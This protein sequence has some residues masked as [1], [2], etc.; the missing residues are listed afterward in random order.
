M[1][2]KYIKM[3]Y[4]VFMCICLLYMC[5]HQHVHI[6]VYTRIR[7]QTHFL[8]NI[9]TRMH[10]HVR[11]QTKLCFYHLKKYIFDC[12]FSIRSCVIFVCIGGDVN[13]CML[14]YYTDMLT[15]NSYSSISFKK[16]PYTQD[17]TIKRKLSTLV[18]T[19]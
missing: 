19:M 3:E 12:N 18:V 10:V 4:L 5:L 9:Y 17:Q 6:Y 8:A 15:S 13:S 1:N 11:T 7:A 14:H 16:C 2:E